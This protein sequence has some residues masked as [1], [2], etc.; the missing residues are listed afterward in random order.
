MSGK[1]ASRGYICQSIVAMLECLDDDTWER[2]K[3]EPY[4]SEDGS[5]IKMDKVDI[6]LEKGNGLIKFIQVKSSINKFE[7]PEIKRWMK[8]LYS[9]GFADQYELILVGKEYTEPAERVI[10]TL[11][12]D[13]KCKV[14][15]IKMDLTELQDCTLGKIATFELNISHRKSV[16]VQQA[17][18]LYQTLFSKLM[19]NSAV[20]SYYT[21][22]MFIKILDGVFSE[23]I[24]LF[25]PQS[26]KE[27]AV[28]RWELL[29]RQ[30]PLDEQSGFVEDFLLSLATT[31]THSDDEKMGHRKLTDVLKESTESLVLVGTGGSGKSTMMLHAY[32][33]L[34]SD[35]KIIPIYIPVY[36]YRGDTERFLTNEF[37]KKYVAP[38][39]INQNLE[40]SLENYLM[41]EKSVQYCIFID[42]LN[43]TSSA[44]FGD[45]YQQIEQWSEYPCVRMVIS[46]RYDQG[47]FK[48]AVRYYVNGLSGWVVHA[49][50]HEYYHLSH[51]LRELLQ[52]PLYIK[53]YLEVDGDNQ[54]IETGGKLMELYYNS[55]LN[56]L[57]GH[58]TSVSK[59]EYA[60][61]A[62]AVV[63]DFL[64]WL[65]WKTEK[66]KRALLFTETESDQ[67]WD[68]WRTDSGS[69]AKRYT[70]ERYGFLYTDTL[71]D[72]DLFLFAG[73]RLNI[74]QY[75][76]NEMYVN[77][78]SAYYMAKQ[79]TAF[80]NLDV[81]LE[82]ES[83]QTDHFLGDILEEEQAGYKGNS[84]I[85]S[86]LKEQ[87]RKY[88]DR[89]AVINAKLLSVMRYSRKK[90]V[91][92]DLE[93][94]DLRNV[95]F[96]DTEWTG[97]DFSGSTIDVSRLIKD[98][99]GHKV[100]V[101]GV[102]VSE[103]GKYLV[104]VDL[105]QKA[106]LWQLPEMK[107]ISEVSTECNVPIIGVRN[108]GCAII[109]H[110]EDESL[111]IYEVNFFAK[112][113]QLLSE[114]RFSN[115]DEIMIPYAVSADGNCILLFMSGDLVLYFV[116][117]NQFFKTGIALGQDYSDKMATAAVAN[118]GHNAFFATQYYDIFIV[119]F[120]EKSADKIDLPLIVHGFFFNDVILLVN[121][122]GEV[123]TL[124]KD[125]SVEPTGRIKLLNPLWGFTIGE[126][127][128]KYI[129]YSTDMTS[130]EINTQEVGWNTPIKTSYG[131]KVK[132]KSE[133]IALSKDHMHTAIYSDEGLI[134]VYS[135]EN[136]RLEYV[137]P[138]KIQVI[139]S[140]QWSC[141]SRFLGWLEV[142][143]LRIYDTQEKKI[144]EF[145][146]KLFFSDFRFSS[147]NDLMIVGY[148]ISAILFTGWDIISS[149]GEDKAEK[150]DE[151][152][153]IIMDLGTKKIRR[154]SGKQQY[155]SDG[156]WMPQ[157]DSFLLS[158][159]KQ[160]QMLYAIDAANGDIL[161]SE[162]LPQNTTTHYEV[163][164]YLDLSG[165]WCVLLSDSQDSVQVCRMKEDKLEKV[166]SI[167]HILQRMILVDCCF[168]DCKFINCQKSISEIKSILYENGAIVD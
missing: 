88:S 87:K 76:M 53:A 116:S 150:K 24:S 130:T 102:G 38:N 35:E 14:R 147:E 152:S 30:C 139:N 13:G 48:G 122:N 127:G 82:D 109:F 72:L 73:K 21:R 101:Y 153:I 78:F 33:E 162:K 159:N 121:G 41:H 141:G 15:Q 80:Q 29:K 151:I 145:S 157:D 43:E 149:N 86:L 161:F 160:K 137:I 36:A 65:S 143:S 91:R 115:E 23:D 60:E 31:I 34:L 119:D 164:R 165:E 20:E 66:E 166:F 61:F 142:G 103:N 16:N 132:L 49:K 156:V 67:L 51:D 158:M 140:L 63:F 95:D 85:A 28:E 96:S 99:V 133:S 69:R 64:P 7:A 55:R 62:R 92:E 93:K 45:I 44:G 52:Y 10:A 112:E 125:G 89:D 84:V 167:N 68:E 144:C 75:V 138:V 5:D 71:Q 37:L 59:R 54:T 42:G 94:L 168:T 17:D 58:Y 79:L 104:S 124:K 56:K 18:I 154:F 129:S 131:D 81:L 8:D 111:G 1:Y 134:R 70:D 148:H 90:K 25:S 3:V 22:D 12:S 46:N 136:R 100:P 19:L 135:T 26:I 77:F 4:I 98:N 6:R 107:A 120:G 163:S 40:E 118:D 123:F 117:Q 105:E 2:I 146:E 83:E 108:D 155:Q 113:K 39:E 11:K 126:I 128:G 110:Q 32:H 106:V 47:I 114:P 74:R 97:S 57:E 27:N 50:I 9:S